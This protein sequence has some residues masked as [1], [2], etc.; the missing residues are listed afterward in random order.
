M[1]IE[2]FINENIYGVLRYFEKK[3]NVKFYKMYLNIVNDR[4]EN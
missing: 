4:W 3:I 2:N 1:N